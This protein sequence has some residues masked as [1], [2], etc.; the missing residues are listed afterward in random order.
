MNSVFNE[1][2]SLNEKYISVW[3]DV[4]N[5]ESPSDFKEGVDNVSQYFIDLSKK[6]N[7]EIEVFEQEKFGNVVTII[8]NK[9]AKGTPVVLSGHLD[10]VHP[11]GSFGETPVK[12]ENGNI[13]GP[14]ATDCK[15]GVVAGF[16]CMEALH[17]VGFSERPVMMILQSNEEIGSGIENKA[18]INYI[19]QRAKGAAAFL[20]LEGYD[21]AWKDKLGLHRK[22]VLG[23]TFII[24]GIEAHGSLCARKGANAIREAAHKILLIE[25]FKDHN[26]ITC[27]VGLIN[28]GK[29]RNIVAG[30]CEFTVDTRFSTNEEY[31]F[32]VSE[33][34]KIAENNLVKGCT[35]EFKITNLRPSM[36]LTKTNLDFLDKINKCFEKYGFSKKEIGSGAGGS[37]AAE[38]TQAGIPCVDCIGVKGDYIHSLNEYAVLDSLADS[39]KRMAAIILG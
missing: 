30:N 19:C 24:T 39:A 27:N 29:K 21:E 7:W 37:D 20:N 3:A 13:Y 8:M 31:E 11:V 18:T 25:E 12:I 34:K 32:I 28:G 15:G 4:L 23:S 16:L 38:V 26:G 10:T 36:D 1:I 9:D 17:N 14:G 35:C 2:D 6:F 22:G 33:L 5:I